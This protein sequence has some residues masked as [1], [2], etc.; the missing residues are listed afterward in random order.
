MLDIIVQ[1]NMALRYTGLRH[2]ALC[3]KERFF[4][5][6]AQDSR[7]LNAAV[8]MILTPNYVIKT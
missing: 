7:L 5:F 1:Q 4:F 8:I 3:N 2:T 6:F